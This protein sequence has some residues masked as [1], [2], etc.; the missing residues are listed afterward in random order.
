V[1]GFFIG[2][3]LASTMFADSLSVRREDEGRRDNR[4]RVSIG[5]LVAASAGDAASSWGRLEGNPLLRNV[6]GRFHWKG[7]VVKGALTGT[8]LG[9]QWLTMRGEKDHMRAEKKR[10]TWERVNLG[11]GIGYAGV[12]VHNLRVRSAR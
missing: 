3:L 6:N 2:V 9:L 4:Y 1:R 10:R 12:A 5:L 11:L 7:A 8:I